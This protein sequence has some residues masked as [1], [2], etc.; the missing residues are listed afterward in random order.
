MHSNGIF[1]PNPQ[2]R[3]EV[4]FDACPA[5]D[6]ATTVAYKTQWDFGFRELPL[7]HDGNKLSFCE[8]LGDFVNTVTVIPQGQDT[9]IM[10]SLPLF[11]HLQSSPAYQKSGSNSSMFILLPL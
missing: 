4:T 8:N 6:I 2:L 10:V 9:T 1:L 7:I 11:V 5:H 3:L